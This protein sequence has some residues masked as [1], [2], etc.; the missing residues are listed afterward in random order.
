M[1][2]LLTQRRWHL[3][4]SADN[5]IALLDL[6]PVARAQGH[7]VDCYFISDIPPKQY[8]VVGISALVD[9]PPPMA[10]VRMLCERFPRSKIVLGGKWTQSL[11]G[12]RLADLQ[13]LGVIV[14]TGAGEQ[15]FGSIADGTQP[16]WD[17]RDLATLGVHEGGLMSSRGCP[18]HC[19]FCHNTEPR[20]VR[21]PAT[22]TADNVAL[23]FARKVKRVFFVDDILTLSTPHMAAIR[24]ECSSR[25]IPLVGR[26]QFFSHVNCITE[27]TCAE[28]KRWK[29]N[30]VQIGFESGDDGMLAVME[31]GFTAE[32]ALDK[33]RLLSVYVRVHGLFLI[34]FPGE[35]PDTLAQ[36]TAFVTAA[37]PLLSHVWVSHYQP[38][39]GTRGY[40]LALDQGEILPDACSNLSVGYVNKGLSRQLL[41]RARQQIYNAWNKGKR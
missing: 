35:T 14:W 38:V 9:H 7:E 24:E 40:T 27:S 3:A 28:M 15:Y 4:E 16:S 41:A 32:K 5:P 25:D 31:K 29:P 30:H 2:L 12:A 13:H 39:P 6:A 33:L 34:G 11:A 17:A 19:A 18:Y 36:T 26:N 22:R 10:D 20:V 1:R 21:F 23:L 8:D 37:A